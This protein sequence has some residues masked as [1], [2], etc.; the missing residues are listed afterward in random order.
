M[1]FFY[2]KRFDAS[3]P[4]LLTGLYAIRLVFQMLLFTLQLTMIQIIQELSNSIADRTYVP[5]GNPTGGTGG[6]FL[7]C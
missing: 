6:R 7:K 1:F 4:L 3:Q 5:L 2:N